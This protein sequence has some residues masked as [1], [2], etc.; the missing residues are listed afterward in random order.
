MSEDRISNQNPVS[1]VALVSVVLIV[2]S[3]TV[4]LNA[5][6]AV[7]FRVVMGVLSLWVL[8]Y[9]IQMFRS[10]IVMSDEGVVVRNAVRSYRFPWTEVQSVSVAPG[11]N[12]T[13]LMMCVGFTL[14]NGSLVRAYGTNSY[15][16]SLVSRF[17]DQ[18]VS[19]APTSLSLI[20]G[21][22]P[23]DHRI[24]PVDAKLPIGTLSPDRLTFWNG[25]QWVT[26][27]STDG[28]LQ[29]DGQRWAERRTEPGT[30]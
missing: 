24:K 18:I 6:T 30:N 27:V 1:V 13:G 28:Q 19:R 9:V 22:R 5:K 25:T 26:A 11:N 7:P 8:V 4:A 14:T 10:G 21:N 17:V 23:T 15:S 20:S 16:R 12:I 29:W 2:A 3:L